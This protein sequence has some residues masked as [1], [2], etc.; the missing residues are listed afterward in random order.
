[1]VPICITL[2]ANPPGV[3]G[4]FYKTSLWMSRDY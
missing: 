2:G 4:W 1:M 3:G